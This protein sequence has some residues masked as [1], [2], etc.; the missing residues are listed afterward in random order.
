MNHD[1]IKI[2]A[3][4]KIVQL[5]CKCPEPIT[6]AIE[7]A[8]RHRQVT[9]ENRNEFLYWLD[10]KIQR[11]PKHPADPE[12]QAYHDSLADAAMDKAA[13]AQGQ[14]IAD[15]ITDLVDTLHDL[16]HNLQHHS[17]F[18]Q[19]CADVYTAINEAID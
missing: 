15:G 5:R 19:A 18:C 7:E 2:C 6:N 8:C 14:R 3:E 12:P 17:G 1:T 9:D 11:L 4:H 10:G 16:N 13:L